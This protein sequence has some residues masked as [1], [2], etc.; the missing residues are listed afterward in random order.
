[1][2]Y[3]LKIVEYFIYI[4]EPW[5]QNNDDKFVPLSRL[6][7]TDISYIKKHRLFQNLIIIVKSLHELG[8]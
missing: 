4:V 3:N 5:M 6:L 8:S 7:K 1:M 2:S